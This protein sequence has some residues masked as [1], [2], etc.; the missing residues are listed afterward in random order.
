MP[1]LHTQLYG[2]N[3][4]FIESDNSEVGNAGVVVASIVGASTNRMLKVV[5]IVQPLEVVAEMK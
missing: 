3:I 2:L 4:P 1:S 5:S